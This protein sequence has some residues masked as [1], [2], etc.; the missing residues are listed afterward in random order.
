MLMQF[1]FVKIFCIFVNVVELD[2][3]T[4]AFLFI[5]PLIKR[6]FFMLEENLFLCFFLSFAR[7]L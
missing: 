6:C 7:K 5:S 3:N 4:P 2:W 1:V